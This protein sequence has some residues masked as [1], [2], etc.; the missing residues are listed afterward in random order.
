M[1]PLL[2]SIAQAAPVDP[3]RLDIGRKGS[4]LVAPDTITDL[5]SGG[6]SSLA[7][8]AARTAGKGWLFVGESHATPPHQ[9]YEADLVAAVADTG[10]PAVV[11]VEFLQRP[12]QAVL[13]RWI[14]GE[15]DEET[16][17]NDVEWKK[18]WGFDW[19]H[20]APLFRV[21][22]ERKIPMVALNVP[23][24]LVRQVGRGGLAALG[25]RRSEFGGDY[26]LQVAPHRAVFSALLGGHPVTGT[27]GENMYSAQVLWDEGMAD[28]ALDWRAKNDPRRER[29]FVVIA[30]SGHVM[31]GQGINLRVARRTGER[32]L[33]VVMSKID[34]ATATVSRGVADFLIATK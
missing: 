24:D 19:S 32:G 23:R 22:R 16:F 26:D 25:E 28:S 9:R 6:G 14:A 11:G 2:L 31:Y 34:G 13:D 27:A 8:V 12:K 7:T 21:C 3:M 30:G 1:V 4:A 18:Q 29:L 17:L 10:R 20:Y 5:T 15:I 33:N